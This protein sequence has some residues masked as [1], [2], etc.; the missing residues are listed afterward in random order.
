MDRP[1]CGDYAAAAVV[2]RTPTK[3]GVSRGFLDHLIRA[4]G[5]AKQA[6]LGV[7]L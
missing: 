2:C 1:V 6:L 3:T 4:R 7:E 5:E